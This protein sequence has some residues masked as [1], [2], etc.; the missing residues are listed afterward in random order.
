M[1][2]DDDFVDLSGVDDVHRSEREVIDD[3]HVD[4]QQFADLGVVA[5]IQPAR[6]QPLQQGVGAFE[7]DAASASDGDVSERCGKERLSDPDGS[8][9][10]DVVGCV[11]EAE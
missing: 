1:A 8:E 7:V 10:D 2:F 9:D 11:N 5:V 4:A 3:E 6:L